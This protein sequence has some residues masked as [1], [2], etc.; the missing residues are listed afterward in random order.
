LKSE[1]LAEF[2]NAING[3][4]APAESAHD[5]LQ[6]IQSQGAQRYERVLSDSG[7][8]LEEHGTWEVCVAIQGDIPEHKADKQ[9]LIY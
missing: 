6:M 4:V 2:V 5:K 9:F 1:Q 3:A 8:K 7:V